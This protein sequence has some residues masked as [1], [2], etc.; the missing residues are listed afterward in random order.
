MTL[1]TTASPYGG[2]RNLKGPRHG[3]L[4]EERQG[5]GSQLTPSPRA[6]SPRP[7]ADQALQWSKARAAREQ[8]AP[9]KAERHADA[10]ANGYEGE[11]RGECRH[12]SLVRNT[13]CMKCDTCES[14]TGAGNLTQ[15]FSDRE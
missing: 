13:T 4:M 15:Q 1:L 10:K 11:M 14:T 7:V 9:T 6:G 5:G 8:A 12:F 3:F 2:A